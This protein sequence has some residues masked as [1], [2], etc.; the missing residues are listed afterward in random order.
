VFAKVL[1]A[2]RGEI[3]VRVIR[4]LREMGIGSVAVHSDVD[5]NALHVRMADEAVGIGGAASSDSYLRADKILDAARRTG[6]EAVH[7]GYGFLSENAAFAAACEAAGV[8]FIGPPASA[9]EKMGSKTAARQLAKEAGTPITPGT[10]SALR[11]SADA[12]RVARGIGFPV[13]LKAAA[14]GGGKGM[15]R[16]DREDELESAF[17]DAASEAE[18]SFK[19][20]EVY[21]EKFVVRP[22]H[23]EIQ[24]LGD[25]YGNLIYLGER[26]CSIQRRHQKVIEEAPSP[27]VARH[28][29]LR[30]KM[31]EAAV[32]AARAAGYWNAGTVEFLADADGEFYF[33]EM[34]TRLQVE[35]PVTE[36]ITGM[37]LVKWQLRIAAG[38]RLTI[39]Q[40]D[41]QLR[42]WAMECRLYAEDPEQGFLPSPGE[43]TQLALPSG[44]GIRL[45]GGVY[46]GWTVPMEYDPLLIK[47]A[48]WA[49]TRD[50]VVAR[51]RRAL[52]ETHIGGI[53]TNVEFF[54][55]VLADAAFMAGDLHTGFLDEWFS[56]REP[57][58]A[59]EE[60]KAAA[61]VVAELAR[62]K[63]APTVGV[64]KSSRWKEGNWR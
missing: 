48:A 1:V 44:P 19:S 38:E 25:R 11:D 42:G 22:R 54:L 20:S 64:K 16:V 33:L 47:L 39:R 24:V 14:G 31:G 49:E 41:V 58:R 27:F 62:K 61:V 51:L 8:V 10:E 53:Q 5:R 3:A 9:I 35:H 57:W 26:E 13:I 17:R 21:I 40:E 29:E 30:R 6:A 18:R 28:P 50:E 15:R 32:A 59:S 36:L 55:D 45:D 52:E 23:I 60:L 12:L 43:I 4:A 46:E 2:N 56:R 34:N 37:D 7:P 63:S